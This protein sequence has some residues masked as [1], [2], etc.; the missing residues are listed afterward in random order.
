MWQVV[1]ASL[2]VLVFRRRLV[3]RLR[4]VFIENLLHHIN[5]RC[6]MGSWE[7]WKFTITHQPMLCN[8]ELRET[9]EHLLS[10]IHQ[11]CVTGA[12]RN[13]WIHTALHSSLVYNVICYLCPV[14]KPPAQAGVYENLFL[15]YC[16]HVY[17]LS[18]AAYDIPTTSPGSSQEVCCFTFLMLLSLIQIT[19]IYLKEMPFKVLNLLRRLSTR[20][21]T[22]QFWK[23]SCSTSYLP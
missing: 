14:E 13:H 21:N 20:L 4:L 19:G 9:I 2:R 8:G 6:V 15:F 3:F 11:W 12:E 18:L 5:Q 10:Y 17:I 22:I 16:V 23:G 7:C 1:Q